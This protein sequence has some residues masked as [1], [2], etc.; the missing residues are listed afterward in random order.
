MKIK[1]HVNT[2]DTSARK[3]EPTEADFFH[4]FVV[5]GDIDGGFVKN[6]DLL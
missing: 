4:L 5:L 1:V 3:S 2:N 6:Y